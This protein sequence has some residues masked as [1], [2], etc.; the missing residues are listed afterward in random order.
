MDNNEHTTRPNKE[1]R[2]LHCPDCG[3]VVFKAGEGTNVEF[4]CPRCKNNVDLEY[5][6][7]TLTISMEF[8]K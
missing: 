6:G 5:I 2:E 4:R 3:S 1:K 8:K 7:R